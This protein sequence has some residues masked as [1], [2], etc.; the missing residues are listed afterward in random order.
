LKI[1]LIHNRYGIPGRGSGEEVAIDAISELL[2][3]KGHLV[4]PYMR[5]SLEVQEMK[6]GK[7]RGFFT[8][9]YNIK[10][11][12]EMKSLVEEEGPDLVLAQNVYPF[13]SPSVLVACREV[14]VPVIMR[15]PNYRLICPNGLFM[16]N[17]HI[18]ERCSGGNEYWCVL[19][20]C[21][22]NIFKSFGYAM[23][24][25]SARRFSLFKN[26]VDVF[27]VLTN[28]AKK[29]LVQ[30]G[31]PEQRV[32]VLSGLADVDQFESKIGFLN[33]DYIGFAGRVSKEKGIDILIEVAKNLPD[34]PFRIAGKLDDNSKIL[35]RATQNVQFLGQLNREQL[36][37][38]YSNARM[39]VVPSKWYEGLPVVIIE[40]MLSG[41]PIICSSIGGLPEVVED[42]KTG[43]LFKYNDVE[44]FSRKI[45][46]LWNDPQLCR[47]LGVAGK[48]MARQRY[49]PDAFYERFMNAYQLALRIRSQRPRAS[50]GK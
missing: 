33:G 42:G 21:E 47:Q 9:I 4:I 43:L 20:N 15:C 50:I 8:G 6:F 19:K 46:K 3:E 2:M 17:G 5:S 36:Q 27:M 35:K 11:K 28:F 31:Y 49:N 41:K 34:I 14:N 37:K 13:I 48:E 44:D 30:N 1:L 12:R 24:N 16:S 22:K 29:L 38:F 32:I 10:A 40:A 26:N 23:R 45:E 7:A 39:I 25:L 18:C